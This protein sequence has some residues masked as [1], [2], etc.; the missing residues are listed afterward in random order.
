MKTS[1]MSYSHQRARFPP[2]DGKPEAENRLHVRGL[3]GIVDYHHGFGPLRHLGCNCVDGQVLG[4]QVYIAKH[5]PMA[6]QQYRL[7]TGH[8]RERR[9]DDFGVRRK[10]EEFH[11]HVKSI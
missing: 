6:S 3:A 9:Q 2:D 8:P 11:R 10:L 1:E 4:V 5:R 7:R